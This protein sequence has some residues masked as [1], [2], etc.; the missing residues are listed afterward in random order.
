MIFVEHFFSKNV[1][2]NFVLGENYVIWGRTMSI[3][4]RL[5]FHGHSEWI[6]LY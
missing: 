4:L 3:V 6:L 2:L 1:T 5:I